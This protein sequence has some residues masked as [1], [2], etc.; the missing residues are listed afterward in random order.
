MTTN[1]TNKTAQIR[2]QASDWFVRMSA[3]DVDNNERNHFQ[4]WLVINPEHERAYR[5]IESVSNAIA[6]DD[7]AN[8]TLASTSVEQA[9]KAIRD[10]QPT[11]PLKRAR[12]W[13][14]AANDS[15]FSPVAL[16]ASILISVSI[17]VLMY[18][19]GPTTPD[20]LH[21]QTQVAETREISLKDGSIISLGAASGIT[22]S[23]REEI[24]QVV[25]TKGEAY[26]NIAKDQNRPF[27]VTAGNTAV[28]VLGTQFNVRRNL[29]TV[30]IA[31]AE[32]LVQVT[33]QSKNSSETKT[34]LSQGQAV[35]SDS[36]NGLSAVSQVSAENIDS[37]RNGRLVFEDVPLSQVVEEI[38]RYYKGNIMISS[39]A[40][41]EL[42]VTATFKVDQ[43]ESMLFNIAAGL[44]IEIVKYSS[45]IFLSEKVK[46]P[47]VKNE[48]STTKN[49]HS[50]SD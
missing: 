9:F 30:N 6:G 49:N 42:R 35:T 16:V 12:F 24:R 47:D 36:K 31:V 37:W 13:Q 27:D 41:G 26:F 48:K 43:I 38:K 40:V 29:K 23:L 21:Y 3:D 8:T 28:R 1:N 10:N 44:S 46:K 2:E 7:F 39:P 33:H 15:Q 19:A 14:R 25:L 11:Q 18:T 34:Q 20:S 17:L 45:G 4:Q 32:G 50:E 5:R 22:V